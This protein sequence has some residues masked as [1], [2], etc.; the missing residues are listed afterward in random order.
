[1]V[2]PDPSRPSK[3]TNTAVRTIRR[4]RAVV[5]GGAGFIGSHVVDALLAAWGEVHV[6]DDFSK[7]KRENVPEGVHVHE[8]DIRTDTV[9]YAVD[10]A[11]TTPATA[12]AS[13]GATCTSPAI[14]A[15]PRATS[16]SIALDGPS[17]R[18][19]GCLR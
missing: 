16:L 10:R 14:V 18:R 5:T 8:G 9:E 6:L 15:S 1:M 3:V 2:L 12:S 7:G 4:V 17:R 19:R 13:S 11:A